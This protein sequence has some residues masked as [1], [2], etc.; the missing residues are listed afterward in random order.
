M[1]ID[2]GHLF[3]EAPFR[4]FKNLIA[5]ASLALRIMNDHPLYS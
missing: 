1:E 3:L 2:L 4:S 5:M